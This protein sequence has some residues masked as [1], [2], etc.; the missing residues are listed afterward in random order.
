MEAIWRNNMIEVKDKKDCCG[1]N[2]CGDVCPRDAIRFEKDEEGFLYP[3]VE[4]GKCVSCGLCEKV[5]PQLHI[6]ELKRNEFAEPECYAATHKNFA[7]LFDSTSGGAFSALANV[8]YRKGGFVGGAIW[9]EDFSISQYISDKKGDLPRLRSSKYAQSDARGFYKALKAAVAT[10]K[11]VLVCGCPCQM[12]ALKA[13]IGRDCENLYI[14]DFICRGI[15]SPLVWRKYLDWQEE[16]NGGKVVY[17]KPKNKELGWRNLTT[18]L[19]FDNGKI[20]YDTKTTS[21]FTKGYLKTNAYC[22][23]SC[24]VCKYKGVPRV[25]DVT[26][27]DF[28]GANS[29]SLS[30]EIDKDLGTSLVLVNN[31]KGEKL[32]KEASASLEVISLSWAEA[33]K[34][35]AM[36]FGCLPPPKCDREAFFEE[37]R[38]NGFEGVVRRYIDAL[39]HDEAT[40]FFSKFKKWVRRQILVFKR[41]K[42]SPSAWFRIL[43]Y[44]KFSSVILGHPLIFAASKV[45]I[46]CA[47]QILLGGDL[48]LGHGYF[49]EPNRSTALAVRKGG[50]LITHGKLTL[51]CGANIEVFE[52]ACLEFGGE[53][54][55]SL[56]STIICAERI[57]IDRHVMAGRNVTVR[58]NNGGHYI[59]FP[60]YKNSKPV[61]IGEHAWLCEGCTVM[62]GVKIGAGAIVGAKA[63]V[64][65]KVPANS[66]VVG[67][68]A[69]VTCENVEWKY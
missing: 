57:K 27:A 42:F 9:N 69:E 23:P 60:S 16:R 52:N 37:L 61:E 17:V 4:Q 20:I 31:S 8:I 29:V 35:N 36:I 64:F 56:D 48:M 66:M 15:N 54:G 49:K 63:V 50:S 21:F 58:D 26:V 65:G 32:F 46:E 40:T 11:P 39:E 3:V 33:Q 5:C 18:K 13:F 67:N 25:S 6:K 7:T 24:Y 51:R 68:P 47:G 38:N 1:C 55:F 53:G 2:A 59:N 43:K 30:R 19:V 34:G 12:F 44:N 14:V 28:W 10:G 45:Q 62:S 22:R 41:V